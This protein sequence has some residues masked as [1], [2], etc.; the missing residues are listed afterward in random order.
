MLGQ[1][2]SCKKFLGYEVDKGAGGRNL[3]AV[4]MRIVNSSVRS[5][6]KGGRHGWYWV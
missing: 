4:L 5:R 3:F 1:Q 2:S 6:E